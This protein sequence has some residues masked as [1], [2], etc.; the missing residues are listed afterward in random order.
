VHRHGDRDGRP[1]RGELLEH[2]QVDLVGLAAAAELLRIGQPEQARPA[3]GREEAL[4]VGLGALVVVHARRQFL[5]GDLARQL[6]ERPGLV[7]GQE[8]VDRHG[9]SYRVLSVLRTERQYR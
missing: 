2:L 5:V 8:P 3:Q 6:D 4:G 1:P 9:V 7:G